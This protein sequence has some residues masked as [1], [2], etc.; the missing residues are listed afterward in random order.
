M[1]T[2]SYHLAD[3]VKT[4]T[5]EAPNI[6]NFKLLLKEFRENPRYDDF[7]LYVHGGFAGYLM[8]NP[9]WATRDV[10][11]FIG[12][13]KIL[14]TQELHGLMLFLLY[15]GNKYSLRL[16]VKYFTEHETPYTLA[17]GTNVQYITIYNK[18]SVNDNVEINLET[19][20]KKIDD[21][22]FVVDSAYEMAE[23]DLKRMNQGLILYKGVEL[24]KY[25][26]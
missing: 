19:I 13:K 8:D 11:I 14:D 4:S 12:R 21:S 10:D 2:V 9:Q 23:K 3:L 17:W 1:V 5:V 7:D 24:K 26:F 22:L 15:L 18:V 20:S 6:M 25:N 16:D